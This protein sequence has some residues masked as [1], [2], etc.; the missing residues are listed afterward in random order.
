MKPH[1]DIEQRKQLHGNEYVS[2]FQQKSPA[3]LCS[4]V[5]RMELKVGS[6]VI[7]FGCGDGI[8]VEYIKDIIRSY[9]GVDFSPEFI[10]VANNRKEALHAANVNFECNSIVEFS[11]QH[12]NA[13]D[14]GFSFDL[15]EH[16]YDDEWQDIVIAMYQC[17]RPGGSFYLHTPNEDFLLEIMKKNNFLLKQFPEHISVRN[18]QSNCNFL[19]KAGFEDIKVSFIAHYNLCRLIHPLSR[20]PLVGKFFQARLF[21]TARKPIN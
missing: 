20:L 5:D 3:R 15:S 12:G 14:I 8:I 10:Q 2:R 6:E 11:K 18:A 7:D 16:V 21:I 19:S 17:L 1:L 4:L 9:K 13:F